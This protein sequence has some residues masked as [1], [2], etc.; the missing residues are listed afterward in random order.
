MK[1]LDLKVSLTE[2][3]SDYKNP[4]PDF[5]VAIVH[6]HL[7][8]AWQK[9]RLKYRESLAIA[10][11]TASLEAH[12]FRT[13][14][15]N[16]EL[17]GIAPDRVAA[18]LLEDPALGLIGISAKSQR[19]YR[20][21]KDIARIVKATRPSVHITV[22]GVFPSAADI[23][24][25]EDCQDIDSI[26]RGEGEYAIV[27]LAGRVS[28]GQ[29]LS[30]MRGLT[31]RDG[32]KPRRTA[33]RA[34][35]RDLDAL[36][37]P[38]RHDLDFMLRHDI[39]GATS[40]YLVASRGCFAACTFCSIH[41]I[42]GDHNV[43]RRSPASIVD[44]MQHVIDG[45]GVRRFS[46]VDDLFIMPSKN[47]IRWVHEFCDVIAERNLDIN[48]YAEMRADTIEASL[49]RR[50]V[51]AGM[52]RLFIGVESGVDSVLLRWDKGTTVE[53]NNKA[54][55]ELR[56]IGLK[57]HQINFGY[58][59]F[60][61]EMTFS[62]LKQQYQW[63][64]NSGY[65]KVQHLQ[66]KMNIYWG[67]PQYKRMIN[68]GRQDTAPLGDRWQY[69]FD[70]P[71][72]GTFERIVRQFHRRY[73]A[74]PRAETVVVAR[75]AHMA[76]IHEDRAGRS[77]AKWLVESM[78]EALSRVDGIERGCYYVIFDRLFELLEKRDDLAPTD[79]DA[80][81]DE[82]QPV[83]DRLAAEAEL[84][85]DLCRTATEL[86]I[87]DA[88]GPKGPGTAWLSRPDLA[89]LWARGHGPLH[90]YRVTLGRKKWDR[91]DNGV[92]SVR[93]DLNGVDTT[94]P[95]EYSVPW[96]HEDAGLAT[97]SVNQGG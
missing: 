46:F 93:F 30:E 20:A 49:A 65:A 95:L 45:Y 14:S 56:N 64:R 62:E 73:E 52:H 40:A 48:F 72:V 19:T 83:F 50:L 2:P 8:E 76:V 24:V 25:I 85:H 13:L 71:K 53:D 32:G 1:S 6:P 91:Y 47:G 84:L 81:W 21:A 35:I 28:R 34:R 80:L 23:Q 54:L 39:R 97:M 57:P 94:V 69:D 4:F 86:R 90:G 9:N 7:P 11:L 26:V 12:G 60:D 78:S 88:N 33:S 42:Y 87:V 89:Y 17:L 67:T 92:V 29:P 16:A 66:N 55:A 70:D 27:E 75:E 59:M 18:M 82:L 96:V 10:Y 41:Q 63:I 3:Y 58:I 15:I 37:F 51:E 5:K 77:M 79:L 31:F 38:S 61:P 44:E 22:G 74:D 43:V 68:Q 36:P